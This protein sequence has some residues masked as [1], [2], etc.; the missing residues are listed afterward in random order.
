MSV[1]PA[2]RLSSVQW[3]RQ[4]YA[5]LEYVGKGAGAPAALVSLLRKIG[6]LGD[7]FLRAKETE[8]FPTMK[9]YDDWLAEL[10][11]TWGEEDHKKMMAWQR[12]AG[13]RTASKMAERAGAKLGDKI[14]GRGTIGVWMDESGELIEGDHPDMEPISVVESGKK[15]KSRKSKASVA[16]LEADELED[17]ILYGSPAAGSW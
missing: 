2:W 9:Q 4:N 8:G 10:V 15:P 7:E 12:S 11:Q 1:A 5:S 17:A 13:M 16:K 14:T 3:L 6:Y